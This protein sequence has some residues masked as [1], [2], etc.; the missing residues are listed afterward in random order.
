MY[1]AVVFDMDGVLIDSEKIYRRCWKKNGMSIGIPEGEM[2]HICDR[3][4]GGNVTSNAR[5]FREIMGET[6]DYIAFR[7]ETMRM[8]AE[9]VDEHGLSLKPGVKETLDYLKAHG[10]RL[11]L[12]TSTVR[13]L[14]QQRLM[15]TGLQ[16][17]F[18]EQVCGDE[19]TE[20]KPSPDIYL[21]ACSKLGVRPE[22][23]VGV[24]DS[25]NGVIASD[26]AGLH[27]VM[28]VDLIPP[29]DITAKHAER[30]YYHMKD[31]LELF[32]EL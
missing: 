5:V 4:A 8:F 19:I 3:V 10:V 9:Y 17:Y 27:T 24:E 2:E 21:K 25:I 28:V 11:A 16:G 15:M 20:G 26:T 31:M 22:D 6:F 1:K 29:N 12:A 30:V 18:D 7:A 13:E 14:A 23:A 32:E